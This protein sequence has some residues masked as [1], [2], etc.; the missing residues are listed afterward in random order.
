MTGVQ[1]CALPILT[2]DINDDYLATVEARRRDDVKQAKEL[3]SLDSTEQASF[4]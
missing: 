2:G 4:F 3:N 1:T